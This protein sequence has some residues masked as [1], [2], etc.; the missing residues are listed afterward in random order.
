MTVALVLAK[1]ESG[2]LKDKNI[3]DFHGEPMF[4]V[5]TKKCLKIF[6]KVYV[7][8]DDRKILKQA[9]QAG[10][11]PIMRDRK[12]CGDT[13]NIPVYQHAM[14]KMKDDF[15]AVQANSPTVNIELIKTVKEFLD[16]Y[17]EV[18]TCHKDYSIY[19]SIWAIKQSKL[20]NYKNCYKPKP[21]ILL[22]DESI[23]IHTQ[24]DYENALCQR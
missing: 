23:D 16:N 24:E 17:D 9:Q 13:P 18:M 4:L 14:A 19:G 15:V 1:R 20:K 12:L 21:S 10:A 5:N 6:D 2:R 8:S 22:V 11:I 3:L 7:S